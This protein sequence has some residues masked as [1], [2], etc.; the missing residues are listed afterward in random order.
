MA[1]AQLL[2]ELQPGKVIHNFVIKRMEHIKDLNL[3]VIHLIHDRTKA[4]FLHIE[5][6]DP[7][8]VLS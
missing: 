4:E 5:K 6:D 7:N 3:D 1:N 2:K 8:K